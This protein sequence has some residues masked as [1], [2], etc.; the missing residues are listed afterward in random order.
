MNCKSLVRHLTGEV[1]DTAQGFVA[2]FYCCFYYDGIYLKTVLLPVCR[3]HTIGLSSSLTRIVSRQCIE[4]L[5]RH[6][7]RQTK[8]SDGGCILLLRRSG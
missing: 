2:T 3:T 8:Y 1:Y 4:L 6:G 7:G 5:R